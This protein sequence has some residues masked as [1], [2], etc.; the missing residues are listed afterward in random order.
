MK[1]EERENIIDSLLH[2]FSNVLIESDDV[3]IDL[4]TRSD[5]YS[6]GLDDYHIFRTWPNDSNKIGFTVYLHLSGERDEEAPSPLDGIYVKVAGEAV[7]ENDDWEISDYEVLEAEFDFDYAESEDYADAVISNINYFQTFSDEIAGLRLL[8]TTPIPDDKALKILQRQIYVSAITCLETFLS[9][10]LINNVLLNQDLLKSFFAHYDFKDKKINMNRLY[11]YAQKVEEI[12]KTEMLEVRYH[13][14]YKVNA[15]Y[16]AVLKVEFPDFHSIVKAIS[17]R[18]DLVHRNGKTKDGEDVS[19]DKKIVDTV[20]SD[21]EG[22]I[23][24]IN[25][26]LEKILAPGTGPGLEPDLDEESIP[27]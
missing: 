21:V 25:Q 12:A 27:F 17:T 11:D 23:G 7:F 22:F 6:W 16:K 10:A 24:K 1:P 26:R 8:N 19:I 9:D 3:I 15:I 5:C 2:D 4:V 14:L 18:H 20:I 13:N